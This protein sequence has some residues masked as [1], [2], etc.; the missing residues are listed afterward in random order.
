MCQNKK[1]QITFLHFFY[2][3]GFYFIFLQYEWDNK[4]NYKQIN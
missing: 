1:Y 4:K 2:G 3:F